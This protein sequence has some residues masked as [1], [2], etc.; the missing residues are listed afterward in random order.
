MVLSFSE[1]ALN[2]SR[3]EPDIKDCYFYHT[4]DIPNHGT[5]H[6]QWDMRGK[7]A[8]YLGDVKFWGRSVLEIGTASGFLCFAM[9]KMGAKVTAYDLSKQ[10]DWDI[11]PYHGYDYKQE[12]ADRRHH[13][14][15]INNGFWFAHNKLKSKARMVYGTV[16]NIPEDIGTFEIGVVGMILLHLRDPFLALQKISDR[17]SET[18][19]VTG[20]LPDN[21]FKNYLLD[22]SLIRFLPDP[23]SQQPNET[24]W[25]IGPGLIVKFLKVLGFKHVNVLWHK[26]SHHGK[27]NDCYPIVGHRTQEAANR[28][29]GD[30][31]R[32]VPA[33]IKQGL[34]FEEAAMNQVKYSDIIRYLVRR[35]TSSLFGGK[36]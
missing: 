3:P 29:G 19:V 15:E 6:G 35:G 2:L 32:D 25:D 13:L 26:Q 27:I 21:E 30:I 28:N 20:F 24:W 7:E 8:E 34:S 5:V 22:S 9:E 17:I 31:Q 16:Y 14:D 1:D 11:V 36:G 4:M 23:V 12:L 18:I 33:S 10:Y